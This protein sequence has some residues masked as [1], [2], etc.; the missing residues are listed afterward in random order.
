[1]EIYRR[2]FGV[3]DDGSFPHMDLTGPDLD[4]VDLAHGLGMKARR[5]ENPGE[6]A[7]ALEEALAS[8]EPVLLDVLIDGRV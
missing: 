6:I 2:R 3:E 1:M 8:L 7:G 4:F 5:I